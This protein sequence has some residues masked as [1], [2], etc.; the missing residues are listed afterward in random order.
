M[1]MN[2]NQSRIWRSPY[3]RVVGLNPREN[4]DITLNIVWQNGKGRWNFRNSNAAVPFSGQT[5]NGRE[6]ASF[7]LMKEQ[8]PA[9]A[10]SFFVMPGVKCGESGQDQVL[11]DD[12]ELRHLNGK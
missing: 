5:V 8:I 9:G 12:A 11:I 6:E 2:E 10:K 7:L 1:T 3:S 4:T